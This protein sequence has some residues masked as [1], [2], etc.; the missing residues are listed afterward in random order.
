MCIQVEESCWNSHEVHCA[1]LELSWGSLYFLGFL[2]LRCQQN[3]MV[4]YILSL[5]NCSGNLNKLNVLF[6]VFAT[7]WRKLH[8]PSLMFQWEE[9]CV[10]NHLFEVV[11]HVLGQ[12]EG[13][14]AAQCPW[15]CKQLCL[16][17]KA[18]ENRIEFFGGCVY[19]CVWDTVRL[20]ILSVAFYILRIDF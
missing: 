7:C 17:S 10:C 19:M 1:S 5:V 12:G 15:N 13:A 9:K 8:L 2:F 16:F 14:W 3:A 4:F 6:C 18:E 20:E 11:M